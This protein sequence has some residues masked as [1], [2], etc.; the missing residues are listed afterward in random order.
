MSFPKEASLKHPQFGSAIE[1]EPICTKKAIA[2]MMLGRSLC[3]LCLF[4]LSINTAYRANV[5]L[6]LR[7]GDVLM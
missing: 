6:S 7:V 2:N 5:L 1:V 4:T 3:D